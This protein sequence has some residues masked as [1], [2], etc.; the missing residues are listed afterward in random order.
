MNTAPQWDTFVYTLAMPAMIA[1]GAM[2]L[3]FN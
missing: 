2:L 1:L 3:Q